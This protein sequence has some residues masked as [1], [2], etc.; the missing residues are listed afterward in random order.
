MRRLVVHSLADAALD[1]SD[2]Q[3]ATDRYREALT[4]SGRPRDK[5][6]IAYCLAGLSCAAALSDDVGRAG[7]LWAATSSFEDACGSRILVAERARYERLLI[8]AQGAPA[9]AAAYERACQLTPEHALES[10][11]RTA[12][13]QDAGKAATFAVGVVESTV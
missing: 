3:Q 1:Q 5:R 11:L 9:F 12:E 13:R 8:E 7:M 4:V 10:A 6:T 2:T